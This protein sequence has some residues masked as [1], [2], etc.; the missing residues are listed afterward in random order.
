MRRV[1]AGIVFLLLSTCLVLAQTTVEAASGKQGMGQGAAT[2]PNTSAPNGYGNN[3][4]TTVPNSPDLN[5][6]A[7]GTM[8]TTNGANGTQGGMLSPNANQQATGTTATSS[9]QRATS[10]VTGTTPDVNR[11]VSPSGTTGATSAGNAGTT[12]M[13]PQVTEHNPGATRRG[14]RPSNPPQ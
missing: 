1:L 10:E 12:V 3:A 5:Q 13:P 6:A 11:Q 7:T 2:N 4:A 9:G 14:K 8:G